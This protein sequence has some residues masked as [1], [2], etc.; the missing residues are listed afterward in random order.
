MPAPDRA[1]GLPLWAAVIHGASARIRFHAGNRAAAIAEFARWQ[2]HWAPF[3][4][5]D[6]NAGYLHTLT[7]VDDALPVLGTDE[8]VD[9]AYAEL[10]RWSWTR[11]APANLCGLDQLRGGLA[12]RLGQLDAAEGHYATGLEW[13]ERE[14]SLVEAG[15][16]LLGL[17]RLAERRGI[18][19]APRAGS[20]G[21][22]HSSR[23]GGQ[24]STLPRHPLRCRFLIEEG[25]RTVQACRLARLRCCGL[26]PQDG[27]TRKS[28]VSSRSARTRW[29]G[30]SHTSSPRQILRTVRRR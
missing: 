13:A 1:G 9:A 21:R 2:R 24:T 4:V 17:A 7:S 30:T 14:G 27:P 15:R 26:S 28:P 8:V 25:R 22:M 23:H 3:R 29:R 11:F 6:G 19:V 16:C 18:T 20:N 12:L 5:I 10:C